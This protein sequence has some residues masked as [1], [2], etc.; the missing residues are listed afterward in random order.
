MNY[1]K[2]CF[3]YFVKQYHQLTGEDY[4]YFKNH[5]GI[6]L[7]KI[8]RLKLSLEEFVNFIDWLY[9]KK[10]LSSL[11]FLFAQLNDYR[12]SKEY[13][14]YKTMQETLLHYDI[15]EVRR[16]IIDNCK[17]CKSTGYLDIYKRCNCMH[18]FLKIRS[19]MRGKGILK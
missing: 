4:N 19:K 6:E 3:Y 1:Y 16:S 18:K 14:D 10:K 8:K 7:M 15:M 2:D 13:S 5:L 12:S 11:N 9:D 17:I